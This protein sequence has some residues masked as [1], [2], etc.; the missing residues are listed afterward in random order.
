MAKTPTLM[1]FIVDR[2]SYG[3]SVNTFSSPIAIIKILN[4]RVPTTFVTFSSTEYAFAAD[5]VCA[6]A[7]YFLFP[8][9]YFV[10]I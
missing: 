3:H 9:I 8:F 4:P 5:P 1:M 6:P 7:Y 2:I 10:F